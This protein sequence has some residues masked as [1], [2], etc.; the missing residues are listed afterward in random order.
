MANLPLDGVRV[1]DFTWAWAGPFSTLQLAH[2]GAEVIRIESAKRPCV[3]RS[4]PPFADNQPG[5]NRAGYFNQY[6]QGKR[7]L[8]LDVRSAAGADVAKR[9]VKVSD[10][11][12][13][14]FAAGV[15][16]RMGLGYDALR[17]VKSDIIM[18]SISGYGQ[19]GPYNGYIA[20]GPP[21]GALSG[22]FATTGY[23]GMPPAEIGIS[24]AD[25]NAGVW[26]ANLVLSALLHRDATGEG[27]YVD[28]SQWEAALMM[29]GE[30]LMEHAL[31]DRT[32]ERI[33][34]HDPQMSPHNTY[35]AL[36]DQEKWV[37]I[38]VGTEKEWQ[39]LCAVMEQPGLADDPRFSTMALRKQNEAAL[40]EIITKWTSTRDRWETTH[41]L[42]RVGVAAYPPLSNKDL[43]ES[44][45]L[46]ERGF[47][48]ALEHPEVGTRIHAGMPWT[49]SGTPTKV[50]APGPLRGADTDAILGDLLGFSP[51]EIEKL[52][53]EGVLT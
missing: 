33:G 11:V 14:N 52:R 9:L 20:Y 28:L 3:T 16:Q 42:Q 49:M 40:D 30:G 29:M 13:E 24:Y 25:P 53:A 35:K 1:V 48:V 34:D 10:V 17:A 51:A 41:A 36:G 37:G 39:A 8:T 31:N 46:R 6:N 23:E 44:E 4:I 32:P 2:L 18:V 22:F 50:R 26:A 45:H 5:P 12:V 27:Q 19:A 47:F 7:S 43:A 15:M 21:A 38:S